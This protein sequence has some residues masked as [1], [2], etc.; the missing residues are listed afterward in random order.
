MKP[1]NPRKTDNT[2]TK[3]K[4]TKEKNKDLQNTTHKTK[5]WATRTPQQTGDELRYSGRV[6][7]SLLLLSVLLWYYT[8]IN[9]HGNLTSCLLRPK[10]AMFHVVNMYHSILRASCNILFVQQNW[11]I[12]IPLEKICHILYPL[13]P[14]L[15]VGKASQL[16]IDI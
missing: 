5:Y 13:I 10:S 6:R 15:R 12:I 8:N 3:R 7:S 4:R 2:M 14:P 1:K 9:W 16:M 11:L